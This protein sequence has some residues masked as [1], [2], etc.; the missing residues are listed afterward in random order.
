GA[1]LHPRSRGR[2]CPADDHRPERNQKSRRRGNAGGGGARDQGQPAH[3]SGQKL[4]CD[5]QADRR[6]LLLRRRRGHVQRREDRESR[7]NVA[8]GRR[9]RQVRPHHAGP[10]VGE[11]AV[12]PGGCPQ[13]RDGSRHD[14]QRERDGQD[15]GRGV[16]ELSEGGG[17]DSPAT[18]PDRVQALRPRHR[19]GAGREDEA[20]EGRESQRA[21][22]VGRSTYT[23]KRRPAMKAPRAEGPPGGASGVLSRRALLR[24]GLVA[25][26]ATLVNASGVT[27]SIA[28]APPQQPPT[29]LAQAVRVAEKQTGGRARK[30]EMERERGVDVYEIKTVSK[31]GSAKVLVDPASGNIIRVHTPWF[32]SS[33]AN[34]FDRD[35]QRKDEAALARLEASSMTLAG[36]IDAAHKETGG[37]AIKAALKSQYGSTLFEVGVVKDWTTPTSKSV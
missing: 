23:L 25:G 18:F 9:R 3:R 35:D 19:D 32:G 34:M 14:R 5:Q 8:L 10:G 2:R 29:S 15:S 30:A 27:T 17:D 21:Q 4:L 24:G 16:H 26:I 31:D 12:L 13:G 20:G 36:A 22:E 33:I 7:W 11:C 1:G 28:Q 37:R 6:R